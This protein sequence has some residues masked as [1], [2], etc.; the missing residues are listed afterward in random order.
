MLRSHRAFRSAAALALALLSTPAATAQ[1]PKP[2]ARKVPVISRVTVDGVL[3][4]TI[5]PLADLGKPAVVDF[6]ILVHRAAPGAARAGGLLDQLGTAHVDRAMRWVETA[7]GELRAAAAEK[8]REITGKSEG[9]TVET[10]FSRGIDRETAALLERGYKNGGSRQTVVERDALQAVLLWKSDGLGAGL[11]P[12]TRTLELK[13]DPVPLGGN[14]IALKPTVRASITPVSPPPKV[15]AA[16]WN[17][18]W[19]EA[20]TALGREGDRLADQLDRRPLTLPAAGIQALERDGTL[21]FSP[22]FPFRGR[23]ESLR[24]T[25]T[26]GVRRE[27]DGE[28]GAEP[29]VAASRPAAGGGAAAAAAEK[30]RFNGYWRIAVSGAEGGADVA[31]FAYLDL[32]APGSKLG[33]DHFVAID[34]PKGR[35][36]HDW[37]YEDVNIRWAEGKLIGRMLDLGEFE[38][39]PA[40]DDELR[41]SW[42]GK[43]RERPS[44]ALVWTR[45]RQRITSATAEAV[46]NDKGGVDVSIL[47]TGSDLVRS[48]HKP[49]GFDGE[50]SPFIRGASAV[51]PAAPAVSFE[52]RNTILGHAYAGTVDG[53]RLEIR[54]AVDP[55][56]RSGRRMLYVNGDR[57]EF[58][59][60]MPA[61]PTGPVKATEVR[62]ASAEDP[63]RVLTDA[64]VGEDL[65]VAVRFDVAPGDDAA[66]ADVVVERAG[67]VVHR[68]PAMGKL[69][70]SRAD[71]V[72]F[73]SDGAHPV[74]ATGEASYAFADGDEL[75]ARIG[76]LTARVRLRAAPAAVASGTDSPI[77]EE[78]KTELLVVI[79]PKTGEFTGLRRS[80]DGTL[81][82]YTGRTTTAPDGTV[83]AEDVDEQGAKTTSV[84]R[85]DGS[86]EV[87]KTSPDGGVE[88][89]A[90]TPEGVVSVERV[91]GTGTTLVAAGV[92]GSVA[93]DRKGP[94]GKRLEALLRRSN[95]WDER[96]G[97]SGERRL[98]HTD[99]LGVTTTLEIDPLGNASSTMTDSAGK[100]VHADR[101]LTTNPDPGRSYYDVVLHGTDW[102][103]LPASAKR[104]YA[105]SEQAIFDH[106][107]GI[108]E[109]EAAAKREAA[110]TR[111]R[112]AEADADTE[113]A[114]VA[115]AAIAAEEE[116]EGRRAEEARQRAARRGAI[117]ASREEARRLQREY[118][119]A[120]AA[121]DEPAAARIMRRQDQ[122]HADSMALLQPTPEEQRAMEA[123]SEIRRRLGDQLR[124]RAS[125]AAEMENARAASL[126]DLK[127]D[128]TSK[129]QYLSIGSSLQQATTETTRLADRQ[130]AD[131]Q[132]RIDEIGRMLSDPSVKPE[133]RRI[134]DDLARMAETAREGAARQLSDNADL[135][136]AGYAIDAAM[137]VSGGTLVRLGTNAVRGLA[138]KALAP[139][140][141]EKVTAVVTQRGLT[142]LAGDALGRT[143]TT[144]AGAAAAKT[145]AGAPG[146]KSAGEAAERALRREAGRLDPIPAERPPDLSKLSAKERQA[147][148]DANASRRFRD[149]YDNPDYS[150]LEPGADLLP[151]V[152]RPANMAAPFTE[153]EA[154]A[155]MRPGGMLTQEQ[156]VRKAELLVRMHNER[157]RAQALAAARRVPPAPAGGGAL[158]PPPVPTNAVL[159]SATVIVNR[160]RAAHGRPPVAPFP[161]VGPNGT[162][163][164]GR[165][166][167]YPPGG[168]STLPLPR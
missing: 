69:R 157:L 65:L 75:V 39:V 92:D 7:E 115:L 109:Q 70:R 139:A 143:S 98:T 73:L 97:P 21:T 79:D 108:A 160:G 31:G 83:Q 74:A 104:R 38:L 95:G 64:D 77:G 128:A 58:D 56:A 24:V 41:G 142:R 93:V 12:V 16:A 28:L 153:A 47:L 15:D 110:V 107:A 123:G 27:I 85:P 67:V 134:L 161:D 2:A 84:V 40:S 91:A 162:I 131:S 62:I 66:T 76:D 155:L 59:L 103:S 72:A 45:L 86:V 52:D 71:S 3:L 147:V 141:A 102:D 82:P 36:I 53:T 19:S 166:L 129:T 135:T 163:G 88:R 120:K 29:T 6:V 18:A 63:E 125:A 1:D 96:L 49:V 13:F 42:K 146:A 78:E 61:S 37:Q 119:A 127:D 34:Y 44:G 68:L 111:R 54:A 35:Q 116:A 124:V 117:A 30:M 159:D 118:D 11:G 94:D 4:Q 101:D 89:A 51:N 105:D 158:P 80:P 167:L 152:P 112:A 148:Y 150:A 138:V 137:A 113:R 133:E 5:E 168:G 22:S 81:S 14:R 106:E 46:S 151:G 156:L 20:V 10:R 23:S 121:G 50:L 149:M 87:V 32:G 122:H 90:L 33:W 165:S 136:R 57:A 130:L 25:V 9:M 48:K 43:S 55:Q 17:R 100:V 99:A 26:G 8:F 140:T 164:L 60:T 126:Q 144:E 154:A 132:A 145:A 114:K